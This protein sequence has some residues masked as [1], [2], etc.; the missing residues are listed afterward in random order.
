SRFGFF[1]WMRQLVALAALVLTVVAARSGWVAYRADASLAEGPNGHAGAAGTAAI[2]DFRREVLSVLRDVP[3]LP[4]RLIRGWQRR[5]VSGR[6][7]CLLAGVLLIAFALS[8][9]A[10]AVAA[11]QFAYAIAVDLLHLLFEATWIGGLLYISVVLL[12]ALKALPPQHRA[13]VLAL[14]LPEFGAA[15][16]VSV[17]ALTLT[18]SLNATIRLTSVQQL[19]TTTYGR[20]LA[21]KIELFLIMVAISAY[22]AFVLR[23]RL[24][25]ALTAAPEQ[26]STPAA[27]EAQATSA[28]VGAA[29]RTS[30]GAAPIRRGAGYPNGGAQAAGGHGSGP[31]GAAPARALM[32]QQRLSDWLHR[33]AALAGGVLLC[34][35]LLAVFAGSLAPTTTA[36]PT[37]S[38]G[39][40]IQTQQV[41]G[42]AV[43]LKVTPDTFGTNT[44]TVTVRD[45]KGQP[46]QGAAVVLENTMLDMDMGTQT[47]QLHPIGTTARGSYSG[48]TDLTM[49]GHWQTVVKVLLPTVKQPL[50]VTFKYSASY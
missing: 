26:V 47:A 45:A 12:P 25:A 30:A 34:V 29:H 36:A 16:I 3:H 17:V 21:V 10:A 5:T 31:S 33:E 48:Q 13:R 41:S 49:E 38:T 7:A 35:A 15:A 9:H 19:L 42:Y 20:T 14:G 18:G 28:L 46:V 39:A 6:T 11:S 23:P 27:P 24:A 22:H 43:T 2:P 32:L 50:E 37:T 1:W 4:L 8:G 40:F 44:F